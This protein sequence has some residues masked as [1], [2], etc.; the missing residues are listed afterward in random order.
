MKA[1]NSWL[2]GN[3]GRPGIASEADVRAP[4][5]E[6]FAA[7]FNGDRFVIRH[8]V[9]LAAEGVKGGHAVPFLAGQEDKGQREVGG[10]FFCD[11]PAGLG[12]GHQYGGGR[13]DW[14]SRTGGRPR[15]SASVGLRGRRRRRS[16]RFSA[17]GLGGG[18]GARGVPA[19]DAASFDFPMMARRWRRFEVLGR[20]AAGK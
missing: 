8:V 6:A 3:S 13:L 9:H 7:E 1:C 4:G 14:R 11:R 15:V 18:N 2:T 12:G 5:G 19:A 16:L 10:A 20:K 17:L